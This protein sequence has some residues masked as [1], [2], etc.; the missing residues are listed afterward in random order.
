MTLTSL[1]SSSPQ[2][3]VVTGGAGFIGSAVV[4][5]LLM[6]TSHNVVTLDKL[7]YA[8]SLLNLGEFSSADRHTLVQADICDPSAVRDLF[9]THKPTAIM[10]LAAESHVDRSIRG[11]ADFIQTNVMGTFQLLEAARS[12]VQGLTDSEREFFRFLHVSTDE[13]FGTLGETGAFSE[14]TPYAP[15]SPYSASKAGSDHLV[16]AWF[17]TYNLPVVMT[18]CSNNYGPY[19]FPEKLIPVVIHKALAREPIPVF[20]N[21]KNMRDWLHVDDHAEALYT[22]LQKGRLGESYNVGCR[23][24]ITNNEVVQKICTLMDELSPNQAGRDEGFRHA[25]LI[26]YVTDRAGHDFRYAIDPGKIESELGW[27]PRYTFETG[28]KDTVKWYLDHQKWSAAIQAEAR[29]KQDH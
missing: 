6:H 8:G 21:G 1:D 19:Q 4:R 17:H 27:K 12:Y 22:V 9:E 3:I 15:N 5:H 14:T 25:S 24:D 10:H 29:Q 7:T 18:N 28:L 11:P 26:S 20:G 16:R 13:V 2:T 23:N